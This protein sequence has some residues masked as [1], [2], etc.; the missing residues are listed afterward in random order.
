MGAWITPNSAGE[1]V[2]L[3]YS[4]ANF[5]FAQTLKAALESAG[6]PVWMDTS[7]IKGGDE[8]IDSI[9]EG[10]NRCYEMLY[11]GWLALPWQY[12]SC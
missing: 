4:R 12:R 2:F 6:H 8:R 10:V 11:M 1:H 5:A 7:E 3:S 9:T